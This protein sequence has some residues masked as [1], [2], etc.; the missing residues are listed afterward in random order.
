MVIVEYDGDQQRTDPVQW[1]TDISRGEAF[2]AEGYRVIRVTGGHLTRPRVVADRVLR[3]MRS[4]GYL[5]PDPVFTDEWSMLFE[6][7]A[8]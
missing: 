8:R 5:G 3:A 6:R 7:G 2:G 1:S 4:G